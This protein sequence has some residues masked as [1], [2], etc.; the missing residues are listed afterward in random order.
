MSSKKYAARLQLDLYPSKTLLAVLLLL[1]SIAIIALL[2]LPFPVWLI[3]LL[4]ALVIVYGAHLITTHALRNSKK[5]IR[6]IIWDANDDWLISTR[7]AENVKMTLQRDSFIHPM[8]T[9]LRF[10]QSGKF[11]PVSAILLKDN[12]N[13]NEF[14]RLRVRLTLSRNNEESF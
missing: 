11:F 5:S 3:L 9:V 12:I 2:M 10:K 14:R 13:E 4:S 8:L 7:I 6:K 1:H